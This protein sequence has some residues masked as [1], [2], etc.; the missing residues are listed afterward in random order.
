MKRRTYGAATTAYVC[1]GS[2][3]MLKRTTAG[4][5]G[6][7]STVYIGG[8]YEVKSNGDV[9]KYYGA[10]GQNLALKTIP[11][12]GGG[13]LSLTYT[14]HLG[15]NALVTTAD[16]T[17]LER[18]T[19]WPFGATRTA[20]ITGSPRTDLLYTGQ[21]EEAGDAAGLGLYNYKARFYSTVT[22]RFV[23][24]NVV[25]PSTQDPQ[26]LNRFTYV[27]NNPRNRVD[28]RAVATFDSATP[29]GS[30]RGASVPVACR[31]CRRRR[32]TLQLRLR[33]R[34]GS[35]SAQT[36][37]PRPLCLY[38]LSACGASPAPA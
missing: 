9:M 26:S 29:Y 24:A 31:A 28:P 34:R 15:S 38:G 13:A 23:S 35:F 30:M 11:A 2:G 27:R 36:T 1:G 12:G 10:L 16:G 32:S 37:T 19:Y 5:S 21:R 20:S 18:R 22:G 33:A 17:I 7:E 4:A 3:A 25:M 14:D 8:L 6:S